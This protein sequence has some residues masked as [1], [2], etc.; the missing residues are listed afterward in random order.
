VVDGFIM[1]S[2]PTTRHCNEQ[3]NNE[4]KMNGICNRALDLIGGSMVRN[5]K[6]TLNPRSGNLPGN[7]YQRKTFEASTCDST[8]R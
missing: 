5:I 7:R 8:T 6:N 4:K 2:L 3:A 1:N